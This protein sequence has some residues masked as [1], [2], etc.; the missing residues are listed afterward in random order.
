M[1][2]TKIR[3]KTAMQNITC[4][5]MKQ[6]KILMSNKIEDILYKRQKSMNAVYMILALSVC[7]YNII[8]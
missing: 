6:N 4:Q 8:R 3:R 2:H 5:T 1:I 7:I